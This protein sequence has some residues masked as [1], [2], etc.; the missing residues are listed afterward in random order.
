MRY[1]SILFSLLFFS[2]GMNSQEQIKL[3]YF[4]SLQTDEVLKLESIAKATKFKDNIYLENFYN[5]D[6]GFRYKNKN[7]KGKKFEKINTLYS[8]NYSPINRE[9]SGNEI[10]FV[11]KD[12]R[13]KVFIDLNNEIRWDHADNSN[14]ELIIDKSDFKKSK[15]TLKRNPRKELKNAQLANCVIYYG[16]PF[17]SYFYNKERLEIAYIKAKGKSDVSSLLVNIRLPAVSTPIVRPVKLDNSQYYR[18]GLDTV[19]YFDAYE[20]KLFAF[21]EGEQVLM[22]D[23]LI[24]LHASNEEVYFSEDAFGNSMNLFFN[25]RFLSKK[26]IESVDSDKV[27]DIG[28]CGECEDKFLYRHRYALEIRGVASGYT[29]DDL[30]SKSKVFMLQC[31]K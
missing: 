8:Y 20:I 23:R 9:F 4:E 26:L 17:V 28:G 15:S 18:F 29:E 14:V 31:A 25:A 13:R 7:D 12:K 21:V 19:G 22:L 27:I 1:L 10:S 11:N 24:D 16:N 3:Y 2:S 6:C 5:K 30:W